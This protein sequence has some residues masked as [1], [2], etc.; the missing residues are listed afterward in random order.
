MKK[1]IFNIVLTAFML[2]V[3]LSVNVLAANVNDKIQIADDGTVTIS[4]THG[5]AEGISSLQFGLQVQ[6]VE[7]NANV[8]FNFFDSAAKI[9]EFRYHEDNGQL[10]IYLAGEE[11]LFDQS[12]N[13]SVG[14]VVVQDQDG[15]AVE[16][17]ISVVKDSLNY[18]YVTELRM[19]EAEI[20]EQPVTINA[21]QPAATEQPGNVDQPAATEQPGNVD[22]PAA[23]EQPG[24]ADQPTATE[25]PGNADQPAA[26]EKPVTINAV[27]P[28]ATEKPVTINADQPAATEKPVTINAVKPAA[29]DKPENPDKPTDSE[30]P[31]GTDDGSTGS[32][33]DSDS[34]SNTA[35][36]SESEN[37]DSNG[38]SGEE[39]ASAGTGIYVVI[40]IFAGVLLIAVIGLWYLRTSLHKKE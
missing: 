32:D 27:K 18:V 28:A 14:T 20:P 10:N 23:T 26:T 30:E 37:Y 39:G 15:K 35:I 29:T 8:S 11:T 6:P 34:K 3:L 4:S 13:L 22:Q 7:Q 16:A 1:R 17:G 31:A 25:Q 21:D 33:K 5:A 9:A 40:L 38:E 36:N 24:I 2:A 12:G 19:E